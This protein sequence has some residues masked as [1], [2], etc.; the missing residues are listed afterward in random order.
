MLYYAVGAGKPLV[1]PFLLRE[2]GPASTDSNGHTALFAI[3]FTS[4]SAFDRGTD[5]KQEYD[6]EIENE[7]DEAIGGMVEGIA[8]DREDDLKKYPGKGNR[9]LFIR[10]YK[11]IISYFH[12]YG[13]PI[14]PS[15]YD[16]GSQ[17]NVDLLTLLSDMLGPQDGKQYTCHA[18]QDTIIIALRAHIRSLLNTDGQAAKGTAV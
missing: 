4:L 17:K 16:A 18:D 13:A 6:N 15:Y 3:A 7:E 12:A 8:L 11:Q 5:T 14:N 2:I 1:I 9:D 10:D